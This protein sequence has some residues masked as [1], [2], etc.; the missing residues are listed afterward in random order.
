MSEKSANHLMKNTSVTAKNLLLPRCY[1]LDIRLLLFTNR[2]YGNAL[3]ER[4]IND[5]RYE[6]FLNFWFGHK[7]SCP[8]TECLCLTERERAKA[9]G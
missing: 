1:S 3:F 4:Q 7:E 8:S 9:V 2:R 6:A 5:R